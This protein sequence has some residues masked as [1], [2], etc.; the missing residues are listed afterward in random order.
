MADAS[1]SGSQFVKLVSMDGFEFVITRDAAFQSKALM[2]FVLASE[3]SAP[4]YS[5]SRAT[6]RF[7]KLQPAPAAARPMTEVRLDLIS[8]DVLDLVCQYLT[9][10]LSKDAQMSDF[11]PLQLLDPTKEADRQLVM[12][13]LL[14]A[15]YLD[16]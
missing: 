12:N 14:A 4:S 7:A 13:L 2:G 5:E 6:T 10:R 9:E 1:L 3:A 15:D 8:G 16:C 11:L